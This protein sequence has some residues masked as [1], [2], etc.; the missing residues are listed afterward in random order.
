M[1]RRRKN[2]MWSE[3]HHGRN[4]N[5]RGGFRFF[6]DMLKCDNRPR[7]GRSSLMQEMS[8]CICQSFWS[9]NSDP[10]GEFCQAIRKATRVKAVEVISM[11]MK[12]NGPAMPRNRTMLRQLKRLGEMWGNKFEK[13][14]SMPYE[15]E[16][17]QVGRR[18]T[19]ILMLFIS[20]SI[21]IKKT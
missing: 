21:H 7:C 15:R 17:T 19:A 12:G 11:L 10:S 8:S 14:V 13:L 5:Y 6:K 1:G 20:I 16:D 18:N 3:R 9:R 2:N 4:K